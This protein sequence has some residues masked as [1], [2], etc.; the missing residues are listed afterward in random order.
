[1]FFL[2]FCFPRGFKIVYNRSLS[3][4]VKK[5]PLFQVAVPSPRSLTNC[6]HC[7]PSRSWSPS[8]TT[9]M[10]PPSRSS[11]LP[12]WPSQRR[13]C[14]LLR[15]PSPSSVTASPHLSAITVTGVTRPAA[16]GRRR[17]W[18]TVNSKYYQ[19][20]G[21]DCIVKDDTGTIHLSSYGSHLLN[22]MVKLVVGKTYL[23]EDLKR[24]KNHKKTNHHNFECCRYFC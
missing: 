2:S 7:Q 13:W 17:G 24:V 18:W 10:S 20:L 12:P 5:V 16:S 4:K 1:M 3:K 22:K 8:L 21:Q 9:Q 6:P 19:G 11:R 15:L 14:C 23:M